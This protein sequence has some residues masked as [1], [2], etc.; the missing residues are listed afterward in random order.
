M[1]KR[2]TDGDR[3]SQA[4]LATCLGKPL[5][6]SSALEMQ[7]AHDWYAKGPS[8]LLGQGRPGSSFRSLGCDPV[9]SLGVLAS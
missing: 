3:M 9:N 5:C 7:P 2:G 4:W 6:L 1:T 8:I